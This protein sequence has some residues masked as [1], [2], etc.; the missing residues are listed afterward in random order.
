MSEQQVLRAAIDFIN[1]EADLL[2]HREYAQWLTLWHPD[3]LYVVPTDPT[4]EDFASVLNYALDNQQ[5]REKRVERLC[6]G[7]AISTTPPSRTIR[8]A[9]R[10]RLL[11]TSEACVRLRCAQSLWVHRKGQGQHT[12]A[13]V[14][15]Q[16]VPQGERFLI[17]QKV[18]RLINAEDYLQM[19]GYIL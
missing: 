11:S 8:L 5:M 18:V 7:E 19:T 17:L 12:V 14:S 13:D 3:G 15:Y 4:T 16:L 6:S 10:Y 1:W 2:D 9:G